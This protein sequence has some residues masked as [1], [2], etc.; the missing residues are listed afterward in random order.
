FIDEANLTASNWTVFEGLFQTAPGLLIDEDYCPLT[1]EHKVVFAGNPV[2]YGDGRKLASLFVE[3]GNTVVFEPLPEALLYED[4]L[5]PLFDEL[6]IMP[7]LRE[8]AVTAF[9]AVY[10]F[11]VACSTTDVLISP[12]ELQMMALLTLSHYQRYPFANIK[13]VAEHYA[14]ALAK[15]LAP[16]THRAAFER[17]FKPPAP[18]ACAKSLDADGFLMT[19]SRQE[20]DHLLQDLLDL[21]LMRQARAR[22][23]LNSDSPSYKAFQFGGLGALIV[24][25]EPGIGKTEFV[26]NMLKCNGFKQQTNLRV[27]SVHKKP[28]YHLAVSSPFADKERLLLK[29]FDEGAVV[30]IDEI[31][32]SFMMEQLL[33]DLLMGKA[34]NH[35]PPKTPGFMIIG[36][37]NPVTMAGRRAPSTALLRRCISEM[38]P[39]YPNEEL[40]NIL[41]MKNAT[42]TEASELIAAFNKNRE[43]ANIN[44]LSPAPSCRDLFNFA[45]KTIHERQQAVVVPEAMA[46]TRAGRWAGL[47]FFNA[48]K[49][50]PPKRKL[51]LADEQLVGPLGRA[52]KKS[53]KDRTV[54][55]GEKNGAQKDAGNTGVLS[56]GKQ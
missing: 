20:L 47:R 40:H 50:Q 32:S 24:D 29:A 25:G 15:N 27:A 44:R 1:P 36:T 21:R 11:L 38:L 17:L 2:S 30:V 45:D 53:G 49:A 8:S 54:L 7:A 14:H 26:I 9:F 13:T 51:V 4:V 3:H 28:F 18:L 23:V 41:L 19:P 12:R 48:V 10:R 56:H 6:G 31:N 55:A 43:H 37:Q 34:P 52:A 5:K 35:A 33:N 16:A 39:T 42:D 46:K 22:Q